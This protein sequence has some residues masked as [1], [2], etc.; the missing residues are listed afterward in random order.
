MKISKKGLLA[1]FCALGVVFAGS[2]WAKSK[3]CIDDCAFQQR[4]CQEKCKGDNSCLIKCSNKRYQC[5][6][7]CK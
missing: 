7:E 4:L 5:D 3:A 6:S 1:V 2:A